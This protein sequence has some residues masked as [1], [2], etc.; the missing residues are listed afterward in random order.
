[1]LRLMG[2]FR[3]F[4]W[5]NRNRL[6]ILTYHSVLPSTSRIDAA[7]ARNVVNEE[8]FAWQ[9]RY[10]AKHFRCLGLEE[11]VELLASDRPLPAYS[12]VVTFDDGFRNNARYAF[13]IL[14][15][16]G[17]P[18]T[19]FV[20][21]GHIG[22]GM[23]LLWT[24]R[25]GRLLR[26]AG[27]PEDTARLELKRLKSMT[28][29]ERD[30]VILE[31]EQRLAASDRAEAAEP[32]ADRYAFMTWS[33]VQELARGGITIGSHTVHHPIMASLDDER[34]RVEVQESKNEIERQLGRPCKLFSYPN[35]TADDFDDCDKVNLR[36]AG[37]VAAATQIA[38]VNDKHTDRFALKRLNI[39]HGHT[40]Q[41]FIAQVS[42][43]W[44]WMRSLVARRPGRAGAP[45][46][47]LRTQ[48]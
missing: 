9:M 3:L 5:V 48:N 4:R 40:P 42:G 39:G 2:V 32:D 33:E 18:A 19:I 45:R 21:T 47:E 11:A 43:F 22:G 28:S 23:H 38:G 29:R 20:T 8:M 35:G 27:M 34:R 44:P 24:E 14:Q 1:V 37:Y 12:A 30:A 36:N 46:R 7:E 16:H 13:P 26:R 41:L 25:V 15:R 17:V 10:L 31:M 6:I